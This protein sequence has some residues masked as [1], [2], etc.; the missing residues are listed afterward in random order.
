MS[1]ILMKTEYANHNMGLQ[2]DF[3]MSSTDR[4]MRMDVC[5]VYA[6]VYRVVPKQ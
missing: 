6:C 4:Q 2:E 3:T 5:W 1:I